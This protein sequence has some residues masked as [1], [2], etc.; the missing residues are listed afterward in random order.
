MKSALLNLVLALL[1]VFTNIQ[2]KTPTILKPSN[3]VIIAI[4]YVGKVMLKACSEELLQTLQSL[5]MIDQF[6]KDP[7]TEIVQ[8]LVKD[9]KEKPSFKINY[10]GTS[11]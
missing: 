8:A 6:I 10:N 4:P 5:S 11:E 2:A 3:D 9:E 7:N 1:F